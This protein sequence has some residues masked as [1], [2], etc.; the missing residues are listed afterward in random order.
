MGLD[1]NPDPDPFCLEPAKGFDEILM[2]A[3]SVS[4]CY[5]PLKPL[6]RFLRWRSR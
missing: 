3:G 2:A 5:S 1:P 4:S 6:S